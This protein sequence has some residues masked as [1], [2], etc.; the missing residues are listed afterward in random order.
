MQRSSASADGKSSSS[1]QDVD[2]VYGGVVG[3]RAPRGPPPKRAKV[4]QSS[5]STSVQTNYGKGPHQRCGRK[6]GSRANNQTG[7]NTVQ[8]HG[9]GQTK[10]E[11]EE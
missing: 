9:F 2:G 11:G 7:G 6:K 1:L 10:V 3:S 8:S 4:T 5:A